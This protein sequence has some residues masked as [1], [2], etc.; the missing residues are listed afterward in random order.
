VVSIWRLR[1]KMLDV[2]AKNKITSNITSIWRKEIY[3]TKVKM[4]HQAI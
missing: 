1:D 3:Y 2:K 4:S